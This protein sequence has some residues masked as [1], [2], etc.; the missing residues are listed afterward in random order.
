MLHYH[1]IH[2][3]HHSWWYLEIIVYTLRYIRNNIMITVLWCWKMLKNLTL[4]SGC[5]IH[6]NTKTRENIEPLW[7]MCRSIIVP[8]SKKIYISNIV[9]KKRKSLYIGLVFLNTL[10]IFWLVYIVYLGHCYEIL[11]LHNSIL[12]WKSVI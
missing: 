4:Y 10:I 7:T 11:T 9:S 2:H 12:F 1:D 8:P 5:S 3:Q 6:F